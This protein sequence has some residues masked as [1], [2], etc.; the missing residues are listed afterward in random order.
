MPKDEAQLYA[1]HELW[2]HGCHFFYIS[3]CYSYLN[4]HAPYFLMFP[5]IFIYNIGLLN[6]VSIYFNICF[7]NGVLSSMS[8]CIASQCVP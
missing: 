7:I 1:A 5:N 8:I 4:L 6:G 3:S 2:V